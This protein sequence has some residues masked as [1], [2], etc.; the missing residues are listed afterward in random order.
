MISLEFVVGMSFAGLSVLA[1]L[2]GLLVARKL[3]RRDEYE[4][5]WGIGLLSAGTLVFTIIIT[6]WASYPYDMQY[7][8]YKPVAGVVDKIDVRMLNQTQ[9][10]VVRLRGDATAYR[11]DDTRCAL[12]HPG[13][14]IELN[15]IRVW[16]YG[17]VD[18][19]ACKYHQEG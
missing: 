19:W 17:S 12:L 15:C 11:C 2:G 16:E 3:F 6:A 14:R 5:S 9:N 10:Y 4:F 1:G 18:G 13:D 8:R 7:H